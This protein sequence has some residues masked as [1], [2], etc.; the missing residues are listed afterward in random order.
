MFTEIENLMI[1]G[2]SNLHSIKPVNYVTQGYGQTSLG[3]IS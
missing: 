1:S 3:K 2:L